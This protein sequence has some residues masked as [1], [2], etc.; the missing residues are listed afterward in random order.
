MQL[1]QRRGQLQ[2]QWTTL[3]LHLDTLES[4]LRGL[5][6]VKSNRV[7]RAQVRELQTRQQHL[8]HQLGVLAHEMATIDAQLNPP[9][10]IAPRIVATASPPRHSVRRRAG[11]TRYCGLWVF[12]SCP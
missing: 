10:P 1:E 2:Q 5:L 11:Q 12:S 4:E 6:R 8:T 7:I 9:L 3:R